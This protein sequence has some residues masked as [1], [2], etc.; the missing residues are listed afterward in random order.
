MTKVLAN[1]A[2]KTSTMPP[3]SPLLLSVKDEV[4]TSDS[5]MESPDVFHFMPVCR[6]TT[7]VG[8]AHGEETE[9]IF[10]HVPKELLPSDR[11]MYHNL[12]STDSVL[13]GT[14]T[15][16]YRNT[17]GAMPEMGPY[18]IEKE[19]QKPSDL[20]NHSEVV[21]R[22]LIMFVKHIEDFKKLTQ[23]DQIAAL[24]ACVM[25]TL[26]L[27]SALF[28]SIEKDAWITPKGEI[29]TSILKSASGFVSL[30][31]NHVFYCRKVKSMALED[32]NIYALLQ[33]IMSSFFFH[34]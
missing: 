10:K 4:S 2:K 6:P 25:N 17:L 28:Y 31:N 24:K 3:D 15:D 5:A 30:H 18:S 11:K 13:L 20:V 32:L 22:K 23:E 9:A 1:R 14:I 33:V 7:P 12:S 34:K 16:A 27:R 21:V 29:P 8:K 19:Y 26:L